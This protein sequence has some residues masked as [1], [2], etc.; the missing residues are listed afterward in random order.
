MTYCVAICLQEGLI[1]LSDTRTNAGVDDIGTFR[2]MMIFQ[3]N[4]DRIFSLMSAGNLAITQA[5]K[6]ILVQGD[7]FEGINLWNAKNSHEAALVVGQA[8][9]KVK[10]RD[11]KSLADAGIE[12]N[13]S[14]I[15]GGQIRGERPRL[16]HL[17]S[18]GNFVESTPETCYLQIGETKYGKPILDRVI[19]HHTPLD[20]A[21]KC[22]LISMDSTLKSN[23][24]VGLPLDLF[25]Y[26][27]DSFEH[28][29]SITIDE[30]NPYFAMIRKT[31]GQKLTEIITNIQ[32]PNWGH[33]NDNLPI[34]I[35]A[36]KL[37][38]IPMI[39]K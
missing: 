27:T 5:V 11:E 7:S 28:T 23:I 15:F 34:G 22:A 9:R 1:F 8:I 2:K 17:Y 26:E 29:K 18:A 3:N 33:H 36:S 16:F 25:V 20:L 39:Q 30:T 10:E 12:F 31:W 19:N 37:G 4:D 13:C 14:L 21:T 6:E 35:S 32:E 38:P 24:S